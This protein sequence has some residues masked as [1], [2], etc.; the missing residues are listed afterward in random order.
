MEKIKIIIVENDEDE[1]LFMKDGFEETGR[2]EVI[3]FAESG[4]EL[5][6]NALQGGKHPSRY[7]F[8]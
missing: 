6:G 2:F 3:A 8:I 5:F 4:E 7:D 1:Q